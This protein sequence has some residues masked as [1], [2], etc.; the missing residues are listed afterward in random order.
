[1][2]TATQTVREPAVSPWRTAVAAAAKSGAGSMASGTLAAL[3]TKIVASL[4]GP[5]Y[6]ALLQ[7]LQQTRDA[8]LAAAT[9]NGQIALV[10][11]L[12][13]DG[14]ALPEPARRE[15]LRTAVCLLST[16]TL[17]VA[18]VMIA[19]PGPVARW[20]GLPPGSLALVRW[21]AL[22]LLLSSVFV[23]LNALL[24][25]AGQIGSMAL[26]QVLAAAVAAGVAW[27]V[28]LA[29][30]RGHPAALAQMLAFPAGITVIAALLMLA[31]HRFTLLRWIR[32]SGHERVRWFA[33]R[34]ARHFLSISAAMLA[35]G[36]I[37]SAV[38][39]AIR[40]RISRAQGFESTGQF[41]AAWGISM[42]QVTLVLAS[43]RPYF[44][45]AL[46]RASTKEE[47]NRHLSTVLAVTT[48]A[49]API[50]VA[51]AV[52]KPLVLATFYSR[53][54]Y[55][56]AAY[57]RWTLLGDY[58]K[59]SS[60]VLSVPMVARAEMR[61]FLAADVLSQAVF[62]SS[63]RLISTLRTPAESAAIGFPLCC[64]AH[65]ALCYGYARRHEFR[66][67][68]KG[69]AQWMAGLAVVL[70]ASASTWTDPSVTW[71]KALVWI[72]LACFVSGIAALRLLRTAHDNI[73][74]DRDL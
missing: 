60:S 72:V 74:S 52:L 32:S 56:A 31:P 9:L 67:G 49:A 8:A 18:A 14:S 42:N 73:G 50:I 23:F 62:F 61:V 25:V 64:A 28:A 3:A 38:L 6:V 17:A 10:Q 45:P 29:V 1:M 51:I 39:L 70:G 2:A 48:L 40:S 44:L 16:A 13:Q 36:L 58:L 27:P 65:L 46:A 68:G 21:L 26:L 63:A 12:S 4:L 71:G 47:R 54:F 37:S 5:A 53:A 33:A 24:T 41:D 11:G 35:S 20:C 7:T 43:L 34:A 15:Y 59:V 69:T 19:D 57:L 55:P 30:R 66:L 22:P